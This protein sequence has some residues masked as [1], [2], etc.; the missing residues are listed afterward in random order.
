MI[1]RLSVAS[2]AKGAEA[3][4]ESLIRW[5][6]DTETD[7]FLHLS[8][9]LEQGIAFL[10]ARSK[11]RSKAQCNAPDSPLAI[12]DVCDYWCL[13]AAS[14]ELRIGMLRAQ[15]QQLP[16]RLLQVGERAIATALPDFALCLQEPLPLYFLTRTL[17]G[18]RIY[19]HQPLPLQVCDLTS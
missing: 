14:V 2:P 11:A 7:N 9:G 3:V 15:G 5:V 6:L 4:F 8:H 13:R 16:S 10:K 1:E 18:Q 17:T 19:A 12:T